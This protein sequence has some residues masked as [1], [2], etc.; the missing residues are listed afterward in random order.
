M[1]PA[2]GACTRIVT[3]KQTVKYHS[4]DFIC[5]LCTWH[6]RQETNENSFET[7]T[8]YANVKDRCDSFLESLRMNDI[9]RKHLQ[10]RKQSQRQCL[11]WYSERKIRLTAS[12]FRRIC[13]AKTA[14]VSKNVV[15]ITTNQREIK[16]PAIRH[17][18]RC[19][20]LARQEY[21]K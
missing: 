4:G 11:E 3:E 10:I 19:E 17:G 21:L 18:I 20:N 9:Q 2:S 8:N 14:S 6:V 13:K 1:T 16:T 12:Y 5:K 15:K 7:N